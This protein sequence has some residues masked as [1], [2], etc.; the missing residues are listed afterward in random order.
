MKSISHRPGTTVFSGSNQAGFSAIDVIMAIGITGLSIA[1]YSHFITGINRSAMQIKSSSDVITISES[2]EALL[3]EKISQLNP[4]CKKGDFGAMFTDEPLTYD[5]LG[6]LSLHQSPKKK[7]ESLALKCLQPR[8]IK[9][10]G[11]F[12]LSPATNKN[13]NPGSFIYKSKTNKPTIFV[14]VT[15]IDVDNQRTINCNKFAD[16]ENIHAGMLVQYSFQ[17]HG[18]EYSQHKGK[19]RTAVKRT[20]VNRF[21]AGKIPAE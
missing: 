13:V 11:F 7:S 14:D 16:E 21:L 12:C 9:G 2:F 15:L 18:I 19:K 4:N 5:G 8:M 20:Y 3:I 1:T 6:A 17:W 10:R